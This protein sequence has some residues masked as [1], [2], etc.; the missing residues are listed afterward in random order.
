MEK[1][2]APQLNVTQSG[3][4]RRSTSCPRRDESCHAVSTHRGVYFDGGDVR[5]FV[6]VLDVRLVH[7]AI[8]HLDLDEEGKTATENVK[9]SHKLNR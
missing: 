4:V 8:A 3:G 9:T 5:L 7:I 2:V 1:R 6:D